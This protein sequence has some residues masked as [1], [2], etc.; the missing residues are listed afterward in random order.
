[1]RP[2]RG[3]HGAAR[4]LSWRERAAA[5]GARP[6][7]SLPWAIW[8]VLGLSEHITNPLTNVEERNISKFQMVSSQ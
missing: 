6:Q 2:A 1:M 5:P 7:T 4:R 3:W 8:H